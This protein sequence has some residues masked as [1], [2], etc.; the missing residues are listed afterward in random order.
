MLKTLLT[1][2]PEF[3]AQ[4]SDTEARVLRACLELEI[5]GK[6]VPKK[7]RA[8]PNYQ[9][10][11]KELHSRP[12]KNNKAYSP[13]L[14]T[15]IGSIC[16]SPTQITAWA[17]SIE[18]LRAELGLPNAHQITV[19]QVAEKL[20]NGLPTLAAYT[21]MRKQNLNTDAFW[22]PAMLKSGGVS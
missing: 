18:R 22:T 15:Y 6:P 10:L 14:I 2:S 7:A 16:I 9:A 11:L 4:T 13:W 5:I 21:T 20:A 12:V 17:Y 19:Q 3:Y 1:L 8:H